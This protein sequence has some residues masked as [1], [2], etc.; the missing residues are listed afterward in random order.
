MDIWSFLTLVIFSFGLVMIIA[1]IFSAYFGAGKNKAYGAIMAIV[2]LVIAGIW[3][4][5][6]VWNDAIA[7]IY[8]VPVWDVVLQAIYD[9]LGILI[10]AL[11][12]VGIFLV[13]VLKS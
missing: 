3:G 8:D 6:A 1:G 10:G 2:G 12:A 9:L 7:C 5:F 4:Y 11:I 13:V